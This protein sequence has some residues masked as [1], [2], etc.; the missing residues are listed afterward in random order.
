MR[1]QPAFYLP[2]GSML[3]LSFLL[4]FMTP[5]ILVGCFGDPDYPQGLACSET[6]TC[7]PGQTCDVDRICRIETLPPVDPCADAACG[8]GTC[9]ADDSDY[10]C[11]CEPGY[12]PQS[13]ESGGETCVDIDECA[14][15]ASDPCAPNG[16]CIDELNGYRC[17]CGDGYDF[18]GTTCAEIDECALLS[19]DPC[20]PGGACVDEV[21]GYTCACDDGYAASG[22]TCA[23][24]DECALFPV[25]PCAPGGSCVDEL[26]DYSCACDDGFE[27]VDG[28]CV[29]ITFAI[30]GDGTPGSARRYEDDSTAA[31]CRDY[32]FPESPY[33]YQG[34]IGD[35]FYAIQPPGQSVAIDVFC[36]MTTEIDGL[37]GGFTAIDP[38]AAHAFAGSATAVR[39]EGPGITCRVNASGLLEGFYNGSGLRVMICQYDIDLG[40]PFTAVRLSGAVADR[41]ELTAVALTSGHTTD[42]SNLG[43]LDWGQGVVSG[44]RGDVL[45]GSQAH[46]GPVL[47][48]GQALGLSGEAVT[49]FANGARIA[50]PADASAT[51][52][53]D[54]V[55]RLQLTESGGQ[56]E[57]YRWSGGR[58]YVR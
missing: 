3:R 11:M 22:T 26:N 30:V 54:T 33:L 40:F 43:N 9:I 55:L 56:N 16:A 4:A 17:D 15:F 19:Q 53:E 57:G 32:R 5:A 37:A 36:D 29:L 2:V 27:F 7:P 13:L 10:R 12:R 28:T 23:E 52:S 49:S 50:W 24:V 39:A 41:L 14:A 42:V 21:N 51:T 48:L 46:R 1:S 18:N 44:G 58:I 6:L 31:S 8:A 47:S 35:G 38:A 25:D 45:I 20:A 34:D